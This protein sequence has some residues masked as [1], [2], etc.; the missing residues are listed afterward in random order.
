VRVALAIALASVGAAAIAPAAGA[1]E[2]QGRWLSPGGMAVSPDG[3]NLYAAGIRTLTFARDPAS[4][5][6]TELDWHAPAGRAVAISPAGDWVYVGDDGRYATHGSVHLLA[7]DAATGLLTHVSSFTGTSGQVSIGAVNDLALSPDGHQLYVAQSR[8]N[9]LIVLDVDPGS[10]ALS[11]A[12]A[13][14]AGSEGAEALGEPRDID[15]SPDGHSLYVANQNVSGFTR[16]PE[17]GRLTPEGNWPTAGSGASFVAV[18]PDGKRVYA[19]TGRYTVFARDPATGGL[20]SQGESAP[21]PG[22]ESTCFEGGPLTVAPDSVSVFTSDSYADRLFQGTAT[23]DGVAHEQTYGGVLDVSGTAWSRDG[24]TLYL[25]TQENQYAG[26]SGSVVALAWDGSRL[27]QVQS[28]EPSYG[29]TD[30]RGFATPGLSINSGALYTNDPNVELTITPFEALPTSL[31]ISN[32]S[33]MA[34]SELRRV[35]STGRYAWR[36][37]T[38]GPPER[39]VK[40]VY[41]RFTG[42]EGQTLSDDIIL[43]L[44]APRVLAARVE[45]KRGHIR[46]RLRASD[47]R[48][49]VRRMQIAA[50]RLHPSPP[51]RF[52]RTVRLRG[53]R[54]RPWVRVID[55]AG[56]RSSWRR[57]AR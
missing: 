13:L 7:R 46:L 40:H 28:V 37:D 57:A 38:S 5:E 18:A 52:A 22:C 54:A 20:T 30:F 29:M 50:D 1:D 56:N 6:L 14:Y 26:A 11:F 39:S 3:K 23:A 35:E 36:L 24:A 51:R 43:D 34:A 25:A 12:Q 53:K 19:G 10:G 44:V 41:A 2:S 49:G 42:W 48:S 27:R 21:G 4:G 31:R 9:A 16:D 47:N 17:S 45:R 15:L 55:G 33:G 32:D 8:S